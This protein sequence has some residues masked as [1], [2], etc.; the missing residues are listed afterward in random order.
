MKIDGKA[1]A[2]GVLTKLSVQVAAFKDKGIIPTLTVI[3]VGDD[4][5]SLSY[6]KQKQKAID[7]IGAK[8]IFE[9]LPVTTLRSKLAE[10]INRF[11]NDPAVHGVIIQR[12]LP[13][14]I[15]SIGDILNSVVPA[16]D[17]DGF[18]P[19][20]PFVSPVAMAVGEILQNIQ[21]HI[22]HI[23]YQDQNI[24][25]DNNFWSWLRT[26]KIVILG[27]GETAGKPVAAYLALQ[28]CATSIIHSQ[29]PDPQELIRGADIIIS[30]V[31]KQG[32]ITKN[33]IST[34][35]I[36]ISVGIWR[37]ADA[38]LHGDYKEDEI[39]EV[40]S[41]YTPTPGGVG[42]VNVASLMKNLILAYSLQSS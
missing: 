12:P 3:L 26:K 11:N 8:C 17:I 35:V 10:I 18:L 39:C 38:K 20:S 13:S 32:V 27:R 42:P 29:T 21:H 22:S 2:D 24:E 9:H 31:G 6:I 15:S 25:T 34:G 40:A 41:F 36:L 37:D 28:Q 14:S 1:I 4:P 5:G 23:K 7:V 19:H 16:K 30:C 33:I